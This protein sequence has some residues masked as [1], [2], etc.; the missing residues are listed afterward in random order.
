M[1]LLH[2]ISEVIA[3][4]SIFP[5]Q[6]IIFFFFIPFSENRVSLNRLNFNLIFKLKDADSQVFLH[7][8]VKKILLLLWLKKKRKNVLNTGLAGK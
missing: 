7:G 5:F 1:L 8:F 3:F 4:Y 2:Y 6:I